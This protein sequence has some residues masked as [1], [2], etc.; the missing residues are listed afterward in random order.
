M[1]AAAHENVTRLSDDP[2]GVR[3]EG[4]PHGLLRLLTL[5]YLN[6]ESVHH[7]GLLLLRL[8]TLPLFL[9]GWHKLHGFDGFVKFLGTVPLGELAPGLFG[10]LVVA[11]QLLLGIAITLGLFTRLSGVF[12]ACMFGFIIL[13]VNIPTNGLIN[14]K[15]GG[16]S[17]EPA[18][19]YFVLGL[20]LFF[21]GPGRYS[22]DAA[23]LGRG[24]HRTA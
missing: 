22:L 23:L 20:V 16:L 5:D 24:R 8:A 4:E 9:H 2:A 11:G 10:V 1:S 18:L 19:Y 7:F 6:G 15:M 17:F 13:A 3:T 21:T 14:A 12:L